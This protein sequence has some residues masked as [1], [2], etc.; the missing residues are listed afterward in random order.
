MSSQV[1]RSVLMIVAPRDFRDEEFLEPYGILT[2][3]SVEV[4][5][6]STTTEKATG[7]FGAEVT[8]SVTIGE[9]EA[10]DY[11]AVLFIGG[12][13]SSV[14]FED[15]EAHRIARQA[16]EQ[17]KILGAICI[18]PATLARAGVLKGRKA[19]CFSS[20]SGE[21]KEGGAEFSGAMVQRDGLILTATGPEAADEFGRSVLA[22]LGEQ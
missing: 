2:S 10:E 21:L 17:G 1:S 8:P 5:V 3:A 6:A 13:G 16:V 11:D 20:V 19:T 15:P 12:R 14:F 18:A 22:M 9:V 7:M 4:T